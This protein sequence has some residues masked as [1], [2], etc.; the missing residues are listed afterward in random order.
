MFWNFICIVLNDGSSHPTTPIQI[1]ENTS[2][3]NTLKESEIISELKKGEEIENLIPN[4][5][6]KENESIYNTHDLV[7][8]SED[9]VEEEIKKVFKH[10]GICIFL[11]SHRLCF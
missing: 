11:D 6:I 10:Y 7:H 1:W 9:E 5:I 4:W 3:P 8:I 2:Q